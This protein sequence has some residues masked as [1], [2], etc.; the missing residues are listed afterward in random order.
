MPDSMVSCSLLTKLRWVSSAFEP[1]PS[2]ARAALTLVI[3]A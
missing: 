1:V 3:E 2:L